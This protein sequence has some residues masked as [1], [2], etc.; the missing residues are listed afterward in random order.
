M[1]GVDDERVPHPQRH[2]LAARAQARAAGALVRQLPGLLR[3]PRPVV[4][5][6]R[7]ARRVVGVVVV[8]EEVP[9]GDVVREAVAV[10]VAAV[11]ERGDQVGGVEEVIGLVVPGGLRDARVVRVVVDVERAVVVAVVLAALRRGQL[12]RV[13]RDL[14]AQRVLAPADAGVEDR[15]AHV[16]A[17]DRALPGAVGRHAGDLP[18]RQAAGERVLALLA[19]GL[20]RV[21]VGGGGLRGAGREAEALVVLVEHARAA[22]AALGRR[23]GA[24]ELRVV[25][26]VQP[27]ALVGVGARERRERDPGEQPEDEQDRERDATHRAGI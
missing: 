20:R 21:P 5:G 26:R 12:A 24:V 18:E 10:G 11:G 19:R 13:E 14:R 16:G 22:P 4:R 1:I 8:V 9:A 25:R 6:R 3:A 23:L 17:A 27:H 15:D 7:V 2:D